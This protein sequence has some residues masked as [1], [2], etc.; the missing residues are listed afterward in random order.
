M[1]TEPPVYDTETHV[2]H[3]HARN[4]AIWVVFAGAILFIVGLVAAMAGPVPWRL[5][6]LLFVMF[7]ALTVFTG[8]MA[9]YTYFENIEERTYFRDERVGVGAEMETRRPS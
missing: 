5:V 3:R 7:G 1:A 9:L 2:K 6:A 4:E 8:L